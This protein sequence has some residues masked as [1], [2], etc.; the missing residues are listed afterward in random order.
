M[1]DPS[2]AIV[3]WNEGAQRIKGYAE[4][5]IVGRHFSVFYERADVEA[6]KPQWELVVAQ[7]DGRFEEEG[8]RLRKDG[9]RFRASVVITALRD[10]RGRL[11]GFG[12]VTRDITSRWIAEE[13]RAEELRME[14][15]RHR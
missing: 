14:A 8:W 6:G 11:R 9:S 3:S 1:L 15:A 2:G 7:R 13:R 4:S 5:E 12:K 10:S